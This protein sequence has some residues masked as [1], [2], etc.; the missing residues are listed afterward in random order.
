MK[1]YIRCIFGTLIAFGLISC[2]GTQTEVKQ[3]VPKKTEPALTTSKKSAGQEI[4]SL[5]GRWRLNNNN[6]RAIWFFDTSGRCAVRPSGLVEQKGRYQYDGKVL[7]I[8]FDSGTTRYTIL[9][10]TEPKLV[11]M[12]RWG[13]LYNITNVLTR[14][15]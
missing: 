7:V 13:N 1:T 10:K 5:A 9:E 6:E 2:G 8:N 11:M 3:D 14:M 12:M 4:T 15:Q